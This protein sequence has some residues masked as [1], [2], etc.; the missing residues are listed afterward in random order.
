MG[1]W[2]VARMTSASVQHMSKALRRID[3]VLSPQPPN[4]CASQVGMEE[5]YKISRLWATSRQLNLFTFKASNMISKLNLQDLSHLG[6]LVKTRKAR[7]EEKQESNW[8]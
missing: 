2:A 7:G 6:R 4:N 3:V 1:A 5:F 8:T